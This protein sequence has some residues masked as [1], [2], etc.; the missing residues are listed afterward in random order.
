MQKQNTRQDTERERRK[1]IFLYWKP[2]VGLLHTYTDITFT[3]IY[4]HD[5]QN[6]TAPQCGSQMTIFLFAEL[7]ERNGQQ[8]IDSG[9]IKVP[10]YAIL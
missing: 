2:F 10:Y 1:N 8:E 6:I 9:N 5:A 4:M 3:Y 7:F